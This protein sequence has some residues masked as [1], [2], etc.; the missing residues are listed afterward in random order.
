M[1]LSVYSQAALQQEPI[2]EVSRASFSCCALDVAASSDYLFDPL[3]R[4][5]MSYLDQPRR[6][7][8][9]PPC[10]WNGTARASGPLGG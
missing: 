2:N 10:L 6:S 3:T 9:T 8:L 7:C 5:S 1:S 4:Y